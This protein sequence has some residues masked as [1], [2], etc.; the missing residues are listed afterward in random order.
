M[1]SSAQMTAPTDLLEAF[2]AA[3]RREGVVASAAIEGDEL[4]FAFAA[5]EAA[6][7]ELILAHF[8]PELRAA[9]AAVSPTG[10]PLPRALAARAQLAQ[11]LGLAV[12]RIRILLIEH[13]SYMSGGLSCPFHDVPGLL[14]QRGLAIYRYPKSAAVSV[15]T[16]GNAVRID[17]A[18]GPLGPVTSSGF[19]LP[20]NLAGD[21][22]ATLEYRLLRWQP[23][24]R[25]AS[26]A[27]FAQDE[28]SLH[29]YY[30][31]RSSDE[32][33][34]ER[35]FVFGN[36]GGQ[37]GP[38]LPVEGSAG[39]FRLVRH[40]PV[41]TAAH[42]VAGAGYQDLHRLDRDPGAD[43]LLG[44]KIWSSETSEGLCAELLDLQIIGQLAARQPMDPV[45]RP[46]P[47]LEG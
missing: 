10:A 15:A 16:V 38:H 32:R 44:A 29:R 1:L 2:A 18:P 24:P 14:R 9:G 40:G 21:F 45:V 7:G 37:A 33:A 47:R 28:P 12:R 39:T 13:N 8:L 4:R 11:A 3:C 46:D 30:S 34:P 6:P 31:Q 43:L 27:L 41:I 23:G 19:F 20:I 35:H 22:T 17:F 5:Q 25:T 42:R 36:L 26:L